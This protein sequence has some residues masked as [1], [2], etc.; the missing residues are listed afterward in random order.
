MDSISKSVTG[1]SS[2]LKLPDAITFK[3]PPTD[4]VNMTEASVPRLEPGTGAVPDVG[5]VTETPGYGYT[6]AKYAAIIIVLGLLGFNIFRMMETATDTTVG[7]FQ[8]ILSAIG[9]GAGETVKTATKVLGTGA[10]GAIDVTTGVVDGAATVL[11]SGAGKET[12]GHAEARAMNKRLNKS[13]GED[14]VGRMRP[15]PEGDTSGSS[16]QSSRGSKRKGGFCYIG[17]D[18]GVRSCVRVMN[19]SECMSGDIFPTK[20]IC[21]NPRL[22]Q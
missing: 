13:A 22:R 7:I 12:P 3:P 2:S 20:A 10:K 15:P 21:V 14:G 16:T 9:Y 1:T 19:G 8:P 4:I 18:S 5:T 11:Q 17:E 6:I